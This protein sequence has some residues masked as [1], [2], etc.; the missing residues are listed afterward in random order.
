[1]CQTSVSEFSSDF[2]MA[3]SITAAAVATS[4]DS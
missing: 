2:A 4:A 3:V 1:M